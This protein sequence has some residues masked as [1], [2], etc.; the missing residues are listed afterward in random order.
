MPSSACKKQ[1]VHAALDAGINFIDTADMYSAGESEQIVGE[2]LR[3]RR[4][5]V[6]LPTKVHFPMGDC[7]FQG[8]GSRRDLHSFPTR[9]SSDLRYLLAD[10]S[11][12]KTVDERQQ[13]LNSGGLRSEEHTSELQSPVHLVC[14]LLLAKNKSSTR[15]SMRESTSSTPPTC[16]LPVNPNRSSGRR[17][18][19]AAMMSACRPRC[20]FRWAIVFF[21][22]TAPAEISTLS[23]HDALPI[24]G[25]CWPTRPSARPSTS[26]S[27]C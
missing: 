10:P 15:P 5:D 16:T 12:G 8:Y 17:F 3:G 13:L 4:D 9:R 25:T 11:L 6:G 20:I 1:I 23:L 2:A 21:K 19:A 18:G 22:D 26:A 27:S 14:R 7:F 24:S